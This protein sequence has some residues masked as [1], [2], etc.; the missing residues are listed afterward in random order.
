MTSPSVRRRESTPLLEK[1]KTD[2]SLTK[3]KLSSTWKKDDK[4]KEAKE[5][6]PIIRYLTS[7]VMR[8]RE[9]EQEAPVMF[10]EEKK[11]VRQ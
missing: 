7:Q 3:L 9:R 6:P 2:V 10:L 11:L 1:I 5:E 4:P 8:K